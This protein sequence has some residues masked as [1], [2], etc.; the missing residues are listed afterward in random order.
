MEAAEI[1]V[2]TGCQPWKGKTAVGQDDPGIECAYIP[3]FQTAQVGNRVFSG[4][5]IV[6]SHGSAAGHRG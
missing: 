2:V 4:C 3:I 6:P 5:G 1:G